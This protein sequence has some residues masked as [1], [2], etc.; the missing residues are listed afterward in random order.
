MNKDLLEYN[1]CLVSEQLT[2][3]QIIFSRRNRDW[4]RF[5]KLDSHQKL[6]V[7]LQELEYFSD[8]INP[9]YK[10]SGHSI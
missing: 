6:I 9:N 3:K 2:T 1:I 7:R 10:P 4:N 8:D 5:D